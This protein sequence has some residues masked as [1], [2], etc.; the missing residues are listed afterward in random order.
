MNKTPPRSSIQNPHQIV[1]LPIELIEP[2]S[3]Q[4]RSVFDDRLIDELAESIRKH[5]V[6]QPILVRFVGDY[7]SSGEPLYEIISGERRWR[8]SKKVG[9]GTVPAVIKDVD[10][11]EMFIL[12]VLEN[13]QR[14]DLNSIEEARAFAKLMVRL[15][16][17]QDELS[18]IVSKGRSYVANSMRLLSLPE[19]VQELVSQGRLSVS[20]AKLLI[21]QPR[22]M[23][24]AQ[25]IIENNLSVRQTEEM[26]SGTKAPS[27]PKGESDDHA[28]PAVPP[29]PSPISVAMS[30]SDHEAALNELK[31][32]LQDIMSM[33]VNISCSEKTGEGKL[34]V[35]FKNRMQLD[36]LCQRLASFSEE[37]SYE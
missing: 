19:N 32:Y 33:K 36:S 11:N 30:N 6:L 35:F 15:N 1:E 28:A 7:A 29:P 22:S 25:R 2:N 18:K 8:A 17:S 16:C 26:L 10:D 20:H 23:I 5:G 3:T 24:L 21:G 31:G 12:A 34:T 27:P 9:L 14:S 37:W 13:I 4:P